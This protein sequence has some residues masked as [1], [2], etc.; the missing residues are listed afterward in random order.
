MSDYHVKVQRAINTAVGSQVGSRIYVLRAPQGSKTPYVLHSTV[1]HAQIWHLRGKSSLE[2]PRI[3]I[4]LYGEDYQKLRQLQTLVHE[5]ILGATDFS[6]VYIYSTE[7]FEDDTQ[8]V[9]LV[10]EFSIWH[11]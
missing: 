8:L 5:A 11:G 6:A 4:E 9:H 3:R 2:N 10:S 1:T 7:M